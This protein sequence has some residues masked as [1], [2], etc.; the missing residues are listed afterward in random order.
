MSVA[1]RATK[2]R[3]L[4][5]K[6]IIVPPQTLAPS[7][8]PLAQSQPPEPDRELLPA[9]LQSEAPTGLVDRQPAPE[10]VQDS[11]PAFS[12]HI[13]TVACF[14]S[15]WRILSGEFTRFARP[16]AFL[17]P[18]FPSIELLHT[19]NIRE[20]TSLGQPQNPSHQT[21]HPQPLT[22]PRRKIPGVW[23][24]APSKTTTS[25]HVSIS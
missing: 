13:L 25:N 22:A 9:I 5:D 10:L 1:P 16:I 14:L 19:Q 6:A 17:Q 21:D 24:L 12:P 8:H 15:R 11:P 18:C 23:R 7:S 3:V 20:S 4:L 2:I